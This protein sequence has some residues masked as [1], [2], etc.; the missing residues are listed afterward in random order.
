MPLETGTFIKD[1][2]ASNPAET[3]GVAQ[4]AD[5]IRLIKSVLQSQFPGLNTADTAVQ[6]TAAQIDAAT[7]AGTD[8]SGNPLGGTVLAGVPTSPA[9]GVL[10]PIG[11]IL[12]WPFPAVPANFLFC[13]GQTVNIT[14]F[15]AL[16]AE[17][18]T[19]YG[20]SNHFG[21]DGTTTF[22][23]PNYSEWT[24]VGASGMGGVAAAGR[25]TTAGAGVP[26]LN[27]GIGS[28]TE[29]LSVAQMPNHGHFAPIFDPTHAHG[30]SDP[31]HTHVTGVSFASST[32]QPAAGP[33]TGTPGPTMASVPENPQTSVGITVG[34]G[35]NFGSTLNGTSIGIFGAATGVRVDGNGLDQVQPTGGN[36]AHPNVQP[37]IG[38]GL[39]MRAI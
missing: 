17:F 29:T 26:T 11:G 37:S 36:A 7:G 22:A 3:D 19:Q 24:L 27:A 31:G 34:G 10:I 38:I 4:G 25:F 14:D 39:I 20:T 12:M 13:N 5:H 8:S 35:G 28:Q 2:N 1:L 15:P 32:S 6:S 30:V 33:E 18:A 9:S 21:G 16:A 23:L